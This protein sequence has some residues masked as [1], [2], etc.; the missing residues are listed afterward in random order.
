MRRPATLQFTFRTARRQTVTLQDIHDKQ[1]FELKASG[2]DKV[3]IKV[4][5]TNG[6]ADAPVASPRSSS[7]EGR[8]V[9]AGALE[10]SP[11]PYA[12]GR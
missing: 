12:A 3:V 2:V 11:S 10:L 4:L 7:S 1:F 5:T 9:G 6:P 8:R